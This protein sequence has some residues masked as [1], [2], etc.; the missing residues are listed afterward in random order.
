M[1]SQIVMEQRTLKI[2]NNHL[3]MNI[4]SYLETSVGQSSHL[5]FNVVHSFNASV[6]RH[7][8]QLKTVVFL[9]WCL[10]RT[11]LLCLLSVIRLSVGLIHCS[12]GLKIF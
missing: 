12:S 4:Y 7:V 11:V 8:W 9:H 2:V 3:N 1:S 10:I 6:F 5:Y